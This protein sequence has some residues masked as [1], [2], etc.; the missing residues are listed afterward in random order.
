VQ[1]LSL[2]DTKLE[3]YKKKLGIIDNKINTSLDSAAQTDL[4]LS[5]YENI[6]L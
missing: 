5:E 2:R 1:L 6:I 4:P 3:Q